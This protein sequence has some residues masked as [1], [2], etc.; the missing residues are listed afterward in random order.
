M[1]FLQK[2]Q[3]KWIHDGLKFI[4]SLTVGLGE[5]CEICKKESF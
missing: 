3:L 2:I 4:T 5:L 1:L